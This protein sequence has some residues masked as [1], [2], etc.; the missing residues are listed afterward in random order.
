MV[1][2]TINVHFLQLPSLRL[3]KGRKHQENNLI[4]VLRIIFSSNLY[5]TSN[6]QIKFTSTFRYK[7]LVMI[8]GSFNCALR[9]WTTQV[10]FKW[11]SRLWAE[12]WRE[13]WVYTYLCL[14]FGPM[15][16]AKTRNPVYGVYTVSILGQL[17]R[18]SVTVPMDYTIVILFNSCTCMCHF[19]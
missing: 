10:T 12:T 19:H 8:C 5:V 2:T 4:F 11:I 1:C 17:Q 16:I 14:G 6:I 15:F 7:M 13:M 18:H 9:V 3:R